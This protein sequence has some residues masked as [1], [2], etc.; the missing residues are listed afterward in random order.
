MEK[1]QS[2]VS[3]TNNPYEGLKHIHAIVEQD[4][5]MVSITNN[6]YEGLKP[7]GHPK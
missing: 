2:F 6:P 1:H 4:I 7:I 5:E 3:I